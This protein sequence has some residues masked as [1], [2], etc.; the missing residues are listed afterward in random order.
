M[1]GPDTADREQL[2]DADETARRR[3]EEAAWDRSS[4]EP[5]AEA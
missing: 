2:I 4:W 5:P 3:Q 1:V